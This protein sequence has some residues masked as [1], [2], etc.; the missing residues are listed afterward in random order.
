MKLLS[1][2]LCLAVCLPLAASASS[3]QPLACGINALNAREQG[4]RETLIEELMPIRP[5]TGR[6]EVRVAV[7]AEPGSP[8]LVYKAGASVTM[9]TSFRLTDAN[10]AADFPFATA[11]GHWVRAEFEGTI[12]DSALIQV[13]GGDTV[14]VNFR[15]A[16]AP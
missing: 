7:P 10:G 6:V 2:V 14:R 9:E 16:P 15:L 11:G 3:D 5:A 8:D 13:Q 12:P 1:L 4:R